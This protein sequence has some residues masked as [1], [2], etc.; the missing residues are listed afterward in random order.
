MSPL[1]RGVTLIELVVVM[2]IVA[3]ITAVAVPTY[4]NYVVRAN[5][6]DAKIATLA[7]AGHLERCFTRYNAYNSANCPVD[8]T[9]VPSP[10]QHY[11]VSAVVTASTFAITA[12]PQEGQASDPCGAFRLTSADE[13]TVGGT[14]PA[15]ECWRR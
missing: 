1:A 14:E 9:N 7:M 11:R 13:R 5:R 4:R 2:M 10:E 15:S 12:T 6:S 8:I 3:I